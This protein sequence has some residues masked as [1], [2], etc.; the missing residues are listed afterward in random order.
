ML[1]FGLLCLALC[2]CTAALAA[3]LD[4]LHVVAFGPCA[5]AG[6]VAF[7]MKM[8]IS[9]TSGAIFTILGAGAWLLRKLRQVR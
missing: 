2:L 8:I 4:H 6:A 9:F 7:Y 1:R 3:V 5:S